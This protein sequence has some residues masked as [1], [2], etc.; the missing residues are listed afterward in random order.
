MIVFQKYLGPAHRRPKKEPE[1]S[2]LFTF[3]P[4]KFPLNK[5]SHCKSPK[6]LISKKKKKWRR[7]EH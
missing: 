4:S 7:W 1:V 5:N 2:V 6:S 3:C